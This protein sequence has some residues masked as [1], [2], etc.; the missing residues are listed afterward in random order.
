MTAHIQV[1]GRN[2][3]HYLESCLRSCFQQTVSVPVVYIDNAS[4]DG[5]VEFVREKFPAVRIVANTTNRGY[6]GGHNDGFRAL[7]NSEVV[8][9]LNPDVVLAPDFVEQGLKG[10]SAE[11]VG[12]VAPLLLRKQEGG[13]TEQG[14]A[15]IIDSYGTRLLPSL[16]AVNQYED[17]TLSA[18]P[19]RSLA[20]PWGFT[21]AAAFLRRRALHDVALDGEVFDEDLFAYR[22]DVDL[23]WRLRLR[24]WEIVGAQD[25]RATHVRTVRVDTAKDPPVARLSWRNYFL[26]LI[27]NVPTRVLI[28]HAPW[29]AL[30]SAARGFQWL[31]TPT[32]WPALPELIRLLPTFSEKRSRLLARAGATFSSRA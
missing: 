11:Q 32:L 13:S 8:I 2:H 18:V 3:R 21:G 7:P 1:L 16:R 15:T 22:E 26:V 9:V 24:G 6:S 17:Q 4:T 14:D 20:Q 28:R 23:S 12:A 30:E 19:S 10:F 25:A 29:I 5:S 27:K 31:F